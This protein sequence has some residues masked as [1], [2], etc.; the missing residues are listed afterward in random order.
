MPLVP[1]PTAALDRPCA[2]RPLASHPYQATQCMH[3]AQCCILGHATCVQMY[4]SPGMNTGK[5]SC[6]NICLG[7][8]ISLA[9]GRLQP[10]GIPC[11]A[12]MPFHYGC[13]INLIVSLIYLSHICH[14]QPGQ[15]LNRSFLKETVVSVYEVDVNFQCLS[16]HNPTLV[17]RAS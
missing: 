15:R 12:I 16:I 5:F 17:Q 3:S 9:T 7:Y 8:P 14:I 2:P 10:H 1:A 6:V 4:V 13:K 11:S